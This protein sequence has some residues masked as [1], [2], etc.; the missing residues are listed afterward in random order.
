MAAWETDAACR[1]VADKNV[2]FDGD[3]SKEA[4]KVCVTCPV[5]DHCVLA[6]MDEQ[7]GVWGCSERCRRRLRGMRRNGASRDMMLRFVARSNAVHL[8][9]AP[10]QP[11]HH[12]PVVVS[13]MGTSGR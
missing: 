1:R 3:R 8:G 11:F 4:I 12:T 5:W 13:A 10:T 7:M 9:M 2:F 6:N